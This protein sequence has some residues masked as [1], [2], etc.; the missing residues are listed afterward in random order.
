MTDAKPT[1]LFRGPYK[2]QFP[3]SGNPDY[4][5]TDIG[6]LPRLEICRRCGIPKS[7]WSSRTEREEVL[8]NPSFLRPPDQKM[9]TKKKEP[10][11]M[12]KTR[13]YKPRESRAKKRIEKLFSKPDSFQ[14]WKR[15]KEDRKIAAQVRHQEREQQYRA[16]LF[17]SLAVGGMRS[18]IY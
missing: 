13:I 6:E 4:Y 8:N 14:E 18:D 9:S 17:N 16:A 3:G 1:V 2:K 5:E 7:T 12:Y 15:R 11:F 10:G